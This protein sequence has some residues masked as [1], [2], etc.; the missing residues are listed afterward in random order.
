MALRLKHWLTQFCMWHEQHRKGALAAEVVPVYREA[1]ADLSSILV[2]AQRLEIRTDGARRALRM[3]RALQVEL[4]FPQGEVKALTQDISTSGLS[5]LVG[6]A[7]PVGSLI[8]FHLKM[9]RDV[10]PIVGRARVVA[11]IPLQGSVRVAI[12]FDKL[13]EA[14]QERIEDLVLDAIC[15]ELR[16]TVLRISQVPPTRLV[17]Q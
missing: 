17:S 9:G 2:V 1:R 3:A 15:A 12:A 10:E 16:T 11:A 5:A 8:S 14:A 6:A 7:P 4:D 13:D